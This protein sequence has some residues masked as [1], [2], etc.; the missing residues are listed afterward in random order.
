[1]YSKLFSRFLYPFYETII[2][3]RQTFSYY[4]EYIDN[5]S[6]SLDEL[7]AIQQKKLKLLIQ[8]CYDNVSYYRKVWDEIGFAPQDFK[9]QSDLQ[10]L[11]ILTKD[12]IKKNYNDMIAVN[13]KNQVI[14]KATGGST[15]VPLQFAITRESYE[16][17]VAVTWR[18]YEWSGADLGKKTAY[19]WGQD[20]KYTF[21]NKIKYGMYN[22]AF[23][24]KY[25]NVFEYNN[26]YERLVLE[27]EAY[28]PKVIVSFVTPLYEFAIYL[29]ENN[30]EISLDLDAIVTG[31]EALQA[32]QRTQIERAFTQKVTNTYGCREF[33]LLAAECEM[34]EG[35]HVNIDHVVLELSKDNNLPGS[36]GEVLITDL[37]NFGMPF[38]RY[39]NGDIARYSE[40]SCSCGR[41]LPLLSTVEGR[42]LDAIKRSNGSLLPGE[43]FPHLLKDLDGLVRYQVIQKDID[44]LDLNLVVNDTFKQASLV[45]VE[46][47]IKQALHDDVVIS[48]NFLD[49]IPK[50]EMGKTRVTISHVVL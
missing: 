1:M 46:A 21:L 41:K 23:N 15:G 26:H 28:K 14:P 34:H 35:M 2:R 36:M 20:F 10:L 33:M 3:K 48:F 50:T 32:H 39:K 4:A 5:Q 40:Q 17:R 45:E 22:K 49:E 38:I 8:H 7:Q 42:V 31:A 29:L 6:L 44:T 25:F 24:R 16:K 9:Q 37:S 12:I 30:I 47:I 11:P 43:F 13:Y 27:L 18:G 19:I